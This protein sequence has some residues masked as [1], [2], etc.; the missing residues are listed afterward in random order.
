MWQTCRKYKTI[1]VFSWSEIEKVLELNNF[2]CFS[3]TVTQYPKCSLQEA[4]KFLKQK[5]S[6]VKDCSVVSLELLKR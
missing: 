1:S 6:L 4:Q 5:K 3:I 2:L